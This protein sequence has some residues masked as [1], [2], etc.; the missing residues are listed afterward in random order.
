MGESRKEPACGLMCGDSKYT[1]DGVF[2]NRCDR[3]EFSINTG[4]HQ[5]YPGSG[6]DALLSIINNSRAVRLLL[7]CRPIRN[8]TSFYCDRM[9]QDRWEI[10][11]KSETRYQSGF[12]NF[13]AQN[14]N[15]TCTPLRV[16]D[17]ESDASTSSAIW[18]MLRGCNGTEFQQPGQQLFAEYSQYIPP[19]NQWRCGP[20]KRFIYLAG[21]Q[22]HQTA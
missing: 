12:H 22:K 21:D 16:P 20:Q 10:G 2:Q 17:F 15:R 9:N 6:R 5:L 19:F 1:S 18:A 14:R 8:R 3:G 11:S 13:G 4:D 7:L